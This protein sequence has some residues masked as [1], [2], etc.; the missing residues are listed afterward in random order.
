MRDM[1]FHRPELS[2]FTGLGQ[3]HVTQGG[4]QFSLCDLGVALL[5]RSLLQRRTNNVG[6]KVFMW[7]L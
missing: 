5:M 6:L 2:F 3:S 1:C 4:S 7:C